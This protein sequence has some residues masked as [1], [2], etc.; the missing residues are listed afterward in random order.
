MQA[1]MM[2]DY[3]RL[4]LIDVPEPEIVRPD[5]VIVAIRA[6]GVCGS[7]L[8]G[9]T[10]ASGRRRPP[11]I[12]GHE[13]S[14]DVVA[15]GPGVED[16]QVGTRVAIHP[17]VVRD[18]KRQLMGMDAP[19]AFAPRVVWPAANLHRLPDTVSYEAGSLV[20]PLAI[21][22]HAVARAEVP[23]GA[24]A[25]V[26]GAGT[27]GLLVAAVLRHR[28]VERIV[29]SDLVEERLDVARR[30]GLGTAINPRDTDVAATLRSLTEGRG[31]DV[32]FEAVGTGP[33]VA[34]AHA[35]VRDGGTVVWI[36]N[37]LKTIEV[38]M[39]QVVT[40]ELVVRGTYGMTADDFAEA[41]TMLEAGVIDTDVLINKRSTLADGP[42][43]FD[44]LI[45]SPD[46]IKC[47]FTFP[48]VDEA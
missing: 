26:V 17:I 8:H 41:I 42:S 25:L 20:E 23:L 32:A 34:Q 27:I 38:D 10:G 43:E 13:A 35:A 44:A 36:G 22:I 19:G 7:D 12:M 28:G 2:T 15:V 5:D 46:V 1:L 29:I 3:N 39:Q 16:L 40:R 24:T 48:G 9:F 31:A 47:V 14:G 11:L 4:E 37:N 21:V 33:S 30:L 45:G 18:G 6:A